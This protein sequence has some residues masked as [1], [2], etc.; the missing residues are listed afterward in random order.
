[1][2]NVALSRARGAGP[3]AAAVSRSSSCALG[4][5]HVALSPPDTHSSMN[6]WNSIPG[7]AVW[8]NAA[9]AAIAPDGLSIHDM[10]YD[11]RVILT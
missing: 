4:G 3:D 10:N 8:V 7:W 2:S 6:S 9:P 5:G 1:M 11:S